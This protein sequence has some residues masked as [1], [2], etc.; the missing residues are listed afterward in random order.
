MADGTSGP[1]LER[2]PG[3]HP[4]RGDRRLQRRCRRAGEE[5]GPLGARR[6]RKGQVASDSPRAV[7]LALENVDAGS[8]IVSITPPSLRATVKAQTSRTAA[9]S[10]ETRISLRSRV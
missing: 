2:R 10:P 1:G 7:G 9:K 3:A 4:S 8:S 6:D 5:R